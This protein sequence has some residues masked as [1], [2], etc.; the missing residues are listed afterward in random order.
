[1]VGGVVERGEKAHGD[2]LAQLAG[3]ASFQLSVFSGK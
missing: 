1:L 3:G 2:S